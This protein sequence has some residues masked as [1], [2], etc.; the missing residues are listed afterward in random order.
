MKDFE[1]FWYQSIR[2]IQNK[3]IYD[4]QLSDIKIKINSLFNKKNN[5]DTK[6]FNQLKSLYNTQYD[7]ILKKERK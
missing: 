1:S 7:D 6:I 2:Y 3:I 4:S 5:I